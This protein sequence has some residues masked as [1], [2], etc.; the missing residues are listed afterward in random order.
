MQPEPKVD[1]RIQRTRQLLRDAL[2]TLIV[3]RGYEAITIQDIADRANV[4][5]TTFYLHYR[6]KEDLLFTSMTEM[7]NQLVANIPDLNRETLRRGF[8][9]GQVDATEYEHVATFADFYRVML[10]P[11]GSPAFIVRVQNYLA[12]V[13]QDLELKQL[14]DPEKGSRVPLEFIAHY[15]AGAEVGVMRWWLN[16][17]MQYTPQEM[18]KMMD[19]LCDFG[20]LW[21]LRIN[22]QPPDEVG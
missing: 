11:Q 9:Q 17:G 4:S 10:G 7:Y 18:A 1:R 5:R 3:E 22:V 20:L 15:I 2:M 12:T 6:D 16:N 19:Y 8:S 14:E 21:A 13:F